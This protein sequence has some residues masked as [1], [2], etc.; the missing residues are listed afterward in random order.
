MF[1]PGS[2]RLLTKLSR[3]LEGILDK[4]RELGEIKSADYEVFGPNTRSLI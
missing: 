2:P 4:L 1:P 3:E